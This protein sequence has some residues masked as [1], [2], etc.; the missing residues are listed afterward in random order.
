MLVLYGSLNASELLRLCV[1]ALLQL[2]HDVQDELFGPRSPDDL[3]VEEHALSSLGTVLDP[4]VHRVDLVAWVV[5][6]V[7]L[8]LVVLQGDLWES[9]LT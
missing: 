5:L 7:L 3:D 1:G 4:S 8:V 9:K 2:F 6:E